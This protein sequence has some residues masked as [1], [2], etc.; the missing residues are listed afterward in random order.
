MYWEPV[1]IQRILVGFAALLEFDFSDKY[2][3]YKP[4]LGNKSNPGGT[5]LKQNTEKRF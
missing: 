5:G 2:S 3:I 1:L 4:V